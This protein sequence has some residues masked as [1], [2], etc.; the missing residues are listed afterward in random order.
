MRAIR[1]VAATGVLAALQGCGGNPLDGT[2]DTTLALNAEVESHLILDLRAD[3]SATATL[4]DKIEAC[5]PPC[6][7]SF[8]SSGYKWTSTDTNI[9]ITGSPTCQTVVL[10]ACQNPGCEAP[11]DV[12]GTCRYAVSPDGNM[13]SVNDCSNGSLFN[14]V[15]ASN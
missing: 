14:Y 12:T 13:L 2:W 10:C 5:D 9:T 8:V 7:G 4:T 6:T 15:R 1:I 3:G 11:P